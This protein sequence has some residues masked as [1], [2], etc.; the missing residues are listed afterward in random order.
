MAV[1]AM[2]PCNT[3]R[4]QAVLAASRVQVV[5]VDG[6]AGGDLVSGAGLGEV[7]PEEGSRGMFPVNEIK[8]VLE[9]CGPSSGWKGR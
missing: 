5:V 3:P 4:A 8:P 2:Q 1:A 6:G 7:D 9:S